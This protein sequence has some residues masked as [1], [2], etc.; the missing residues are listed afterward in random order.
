MDIFLGVRSSLVGF[1][2]QKLDN[3]GSNSSLLRF[4]ENQ[5]LSWNLSKKRKQTLAQ[6][7]TE[8]L[9]ASGLQYTQVAKKRSNSNKRTTKEAFL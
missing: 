6:A 7:V 9:H 5:N 4:Y 8:L 3:Q 2:G 1:G